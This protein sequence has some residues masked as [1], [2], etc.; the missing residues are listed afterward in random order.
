MVS[1]FLLII[2]AVFSA[3]ALPLML[4]YVVM[5]FVMTIYCLTANK[6]PS[7]KLFLLDSTLAMLAFIL[8]FSFTLAILF[9]A[10]T[11]CRFI[12]HESLLLET[13]FFLTSLMSLAA[14]LCLAKRFICLFKSF[15]LLNSRHPAKLP[16]G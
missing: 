10:D 5:N 6:N 3:I 14:G 8:C 7:F 13:L 9:C 11:G 16:L 2:G 15:S 12:S 4:L 1:E